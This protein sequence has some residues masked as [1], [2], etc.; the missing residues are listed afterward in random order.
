MFYE[1]GEPEDEKTEEDLFLEAKCSELIAKL[2]KNPQFNMT[3]KSNIWI[4]KPGGLS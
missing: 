1:G 4:L 2:K 3:G